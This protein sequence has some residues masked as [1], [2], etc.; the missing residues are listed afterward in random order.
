M[1]DNFPP[2]EQAPSP[3]IPPPRPPFAPPPIIAPPPPPAPAP[4]KGAILWKIL[5]VILFLLLCVSLFGNFVSYVSHNLMPTGR[6]SF[7]KEHALEES[8]IDAKNSD[9]KIAVISIE[10]VI[11]GGN[12]DHSSM[13]L[14]E[15]VS[16]QLKAAKKDDDVKAVILKVNSPGGEVLPSDEINAAITKFQNETRKPVITSMGTLAASGGY[17]VSA[18]SRWIVAHQLTITGSIGVIMHGFNY[19]GLMDKVGLRPETYKSGKFKDMLSG[20][21]EPDLD[22]LSTEDRENREEEKRMVQSLINE[23]FA[24][25]KEVVKAG[26]TNAYALNQKAGHALA[27]DWEDYADGRVF[28]GKEALEH[29]FVDELGNFDVAV[30]RAKILANI[31]NANLIEY[32]APMDLGLLFRLLSKTDAPAIKVDL[33]MNLPKLEAGR[34][35]F[36]MP[37]ALS[38]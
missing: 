11:T 29:G 30:E 21:Q 38:H 20:D 4:R 17:Y 22:K 8:V 32:K 1:D 9:N 28:S 36:M 19:R 6:Q 23:T 15:F 31:K 16:E 14:V 26:R 7:E 10:G 13:N 25:F 34:L 33:G 3:V 5:V 2:V 12:I 24:R 27:D 37:T 35:Y 18:P